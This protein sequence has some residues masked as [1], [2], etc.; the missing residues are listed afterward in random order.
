MT[1]ACSFSHVMC[2]LSELRCNFLLPRLNTCLI[3]PHHLFNVQRHIAI[4]VKKFLPIL[5]VFSK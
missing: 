5:K 1:N 4:T 3:Q 2:R